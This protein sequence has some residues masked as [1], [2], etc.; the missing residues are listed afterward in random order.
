M[1]ESENQ[2]RL[3]GLDRGSS[4][5]T[6]APITSPSASNNADRLLGLKRQSQKSN[7]SFPP[8]GTLQSGA[9]RS[10]RSFLL[11]MVI[12]ALVTS[13]L[14]VIVFAASGEMADTAP[15][16]IPT[17][18][19]VS[20]FPTQAS[21]PDAE[22]DE[23]LFSPPN[24]FPDLISK[25]KASTFVIDCPLGQGSGFVLDVSSLAGEP[26]SVIVTNQHVVEG[27]EGE[28]ELTITAQ[29]GTYTGSALAT[30]KDMDLATI[31]VPG[32]NLP[33]L[34]PADAS[35]VG[36][37]A[38][39]YGAPLG[40]SDTASFGYVTNV[41]PDEF[42]ITTDAILGPGNSGGPLVNNRG[43]VLGVVS[44]VLREADGI[45]IAMPPEGFCVSL[46]TC[47]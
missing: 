4:A 28:S 44:A 8:P 21:K 5:S 37:W 42:L 24:S 35:Q 26:D 6:K 7:S 38:M 13:I 43:E 25:V 47:R 2:N 20:S 32:M 17:P 41:K 30:D 19:N 23:S 16:M 22:I 40:I 39:A 14:G 10:K 9:S 18:P 45:G 46:L 11:P 33:A 29:S 1:S 27:C 34:K 36:E 3:D 31:E 15:A 12:L